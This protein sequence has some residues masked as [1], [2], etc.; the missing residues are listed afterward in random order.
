MEE[1]ISIGASERVDRVVNRTNFTMRPTAGSGDSWGGRVMGTETGVN[2]EL[3]VIGEFEKNYPGSSHQ[4]TLIHFLQTP[5]SP[6][7][8]F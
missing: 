6:L 1:D 7:T 4:I 3:A 5:Q 2:N 8:H